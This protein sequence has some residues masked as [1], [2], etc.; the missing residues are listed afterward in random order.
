M[1]IVPKAIA[2]FTTA[3]PPVLDS[4][5]AALVEANRPAR[6]MARA[7]DPVVVNDEHDEQDDRSKQQPPCDDVPPP[8]DCESHCGEERHQPCVTHARID[9]SPSRKRRLSRVQMI[10]ILARG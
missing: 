1:V 3:D 8:E 4:S 9:C 2:G 5:E 10:A 6:R 7:Q